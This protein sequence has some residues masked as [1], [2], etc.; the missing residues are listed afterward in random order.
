MA[1]NI[2]RNISLRHSRGTVAARVALCLLGTIALVAT[3]AAAAQTGLPDTLARIK[4]AHQVNVAFSGDSQPF[5]SLD[6]QNKPEGYSIDLCKQVIGQLARAVGQPDLKVNW[7][8]GT[9]EERIRLV[10]SGKADLDCANT[11]ATQ[12]R[13]KDVDF[14]NVI[15]VD[16]GG[17]MAKADANINRFADLGGKKIGVIRGTTTETRLRAMLS[18]RHINATVVLVREGPEGTALLESNGVDA[19]AGDKIKL[20]G[21]MAQATDPNALALLT[22]DLS[23][24]PYAFSVPRN[25]SAFRLEVNKGLSTVFQSG[26]IDTVFA[27]WLGKL[28]R[29]SG[30]LAA[31]FVL[32]R[33]PE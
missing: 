26:E 17:I 33:I 23:F 16:A 3:S 7:M 21:L 19:F 1:G 32:D 12:S 2:T 13:M 30:L 10:A 29:P 28:G 31:L 25:D 14:S 24:E 4:A 20:V 22:D 9:V 27:R 15:F 5:S 18:E 8:V 6:A 11:S